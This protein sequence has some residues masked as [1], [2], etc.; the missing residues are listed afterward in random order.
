ML[1]IRRAT[2][3]DVAVIAEHNRLLAWE[4]ESKALDPAVVTAGV[5]AA[6]AD[7]DR[8]GP[9]YLACDGPNVV[10]QCQITLEWS[11]WRNGWFWWIQGV[12]VPEKHRNCG[13]FRA[14]YEHVRTEA[15]AAGDVLALRLYVERDNQRARSVYKGLGMEFEH[16]DV[17]RAEIPR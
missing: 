17:M 2:P 3:T 11:D 14:L 6:I 15:L 13:V 4:S 7:P 10:G 9:Y 16:Y 1:K 12:Y 5:A 8:K